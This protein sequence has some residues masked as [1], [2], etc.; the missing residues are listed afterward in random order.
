MSGPVQAIVLDAL[1]RLGPCGPQEISTR[2]QQADRSIS[3][4]AVRKAL[5]RLLARG[6]LCKLAYGKYDLSP[7]YWDQLQPPGDWMRREILDFMYEVGGI[8]RRSDINRRL[9]AQPEGEERDARYRRITTSLAECGDL[10]QDVGFGI[11]NLPRAEL[12]RLPLTGYW[13]TYRLLRTDGSAAALNWAQT[14]F[15]GVG[16]AFARARTEFIGDVVE[17]AELRRLLEGLGSKCPNVL[18]RLQSGRMKVGKPQETPHAALY[19]AFE[20]GNFSLHRAAPASFY[21]RC[22]EMFHREPGPLSRGGR[23]FADVMQGALRFTE[24][25]VG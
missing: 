14:Y 1:G 22:A 17:D 2:C 23:D 15:S 10:R 4:V 13:A 3:A 6:V 20:A 19:A 18:L 25:E 12:E 16:S 8:A 21:F 24:A 5:R 9:G 11:W 7:E